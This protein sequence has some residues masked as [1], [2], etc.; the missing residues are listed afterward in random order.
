V[1]A[2]RAA[3]SQLLAEV[4]VEDLLFVDECGANTVM[5]RTHGYAPR[6]ERLK[7]KV[8][9][10]KRQAITFVGALTVSG[11]S[12]PW[13]MKGAMNRDWFEAWVE[14]VLVPSL[15][16]GMV[17][18]MDNLSAHK[19]ERV[20]RMIEEAGCRLEYLPPYSPDFNPIEKA[21]SKF[22]R[23]LRK[24]AARTVQGVYDAMAAALK[25]FSPSECLHYFQCCGYPFATSS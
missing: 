12:A 1:K 25:Q 9:A 14:Q 17:V 21:F 3:W 7:A 16:A 23:I 5:T 10:G 13:A 18:V 19:G 22:K 24:A 2:L 6:S 11:M 20:R 8:P 4:K 15:R